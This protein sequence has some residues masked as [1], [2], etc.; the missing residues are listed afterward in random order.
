[1]STATNTST[2]AK[3]K[4]KRFHPQLNS[5]AYAASLMMNPTAD[6]VKNRHTEDLTEPPWP[7]KVK[8]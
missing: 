7:L 8:W 3:T 6:T 4:S 5:A 2:M 1:V